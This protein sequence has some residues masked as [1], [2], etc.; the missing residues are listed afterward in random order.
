MSNNT[1]FSIEASRAGGVPV[2]YEIH[3]GGADG[4]K[5]SISKMI[6]K[7]RAARKDWRL[8][9][10]SGRKVIAAGKPTS[11]QA[12]ASVLLDAVRAQT[13]Y[14]F[15][16]PNTEMIVAPAVTLCLDGAGDDGG[17]VCIPIADC[18]DLS[19]ACIAVCQAF[20]M[21]NVY[22]IAH[23][24]DSSGIPSHVLFGVKTEDGI[25]K[26][27]DPSTKLPFG[28]SLPYTQEWI[29][30]PMKNDPLMIKGQGDYIGVGRPTALGTG[31]LGDVTQDVYNGT[32]NQLEQALYTMKSSF[33]ALQSAVDQ[34]TSTRATMQPSTPYDP[35]PGWKVD[36]SNL[37][38]GGIWTQS[39]AVLANT[40]FAWATPLLSAADDAL[41]GVR[42]IM[43]DDANPG[44]A[45]IAA[46]NTDTFRLV[47]VIQSVQED[48]V[49]ITDEA[50]KVLGGFSSTGASLTVQNVRD[51]IAAAGKALV[52]GLGFSGVP[53]QG[54]GVGVLPALAIVVIVVAAAAAQIIASIAIYYAISKFCD[55]MSTKAQEATNQDL[56]KCLTTPGAGQNCTDLAKIIAQNRV[57]AEKAKA[58]TNNSDPFAQT[59]S[60]ISSAVTW[61]VVGG[62]IIGGLYLGAPLA[63]GVIEELRHKRADKTA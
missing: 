27:G 22:I 7:I 19:C 14:S 44:D 43:L 56:I 54:V 10:W 37:P 32:V 53:K 52:G 57:D 13:M 24:Y 31:L 47:R 40:L 62:I 15:D 46:K 6:D 60:S 8:R 42:Q 49:A 3:P 33:L 51:K 26:R 50:G 12:Q 55:M 48:V 9:K 1:S 17:D 30:D 18:D 36:F 21:E 58:A 34:V 11:I 59:A 63:K 61:V 28:Q 20:G 35:E 41:S 5:F 29:I 25:I 4:A 39:M 38:S 16:P 23:S 2:Q 45:Y